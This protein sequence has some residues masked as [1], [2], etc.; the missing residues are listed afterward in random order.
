MKRVVV[1]LS[2]AVAGLTPAGVAASQASAQSDPFKTSVAFLC[3]SKF[4]VDPG[5]WPLQKTSFTIHDTASDLLGMGYWSPYAEK[6]AP[7]A[8]ELPDGYY[9]S[10]SLPA[11]MRPVVGTLPKQSLASPELVTQ[12][13]ALVPMTRKYAGEPGL[14][15]LAA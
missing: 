10:C 13:G 15:P 9:L 14:Y 6:S 7:T 11:G 2:I 8:T 1:V 12:K 3:Y 5:V 4:Q